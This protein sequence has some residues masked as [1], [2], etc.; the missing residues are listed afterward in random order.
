MTPP[1]TESPWYVAAAYK[2]GVPTVIAAFLIWWLTSVVAASLTTIQADLRGHV[3]A[4]N[5]YLRAVCL[6]TAKD[7]RERADCPAIAPREDG[8]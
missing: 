8:H 6:H 3:M 2:L 1:R 7:D 4:T 5:I